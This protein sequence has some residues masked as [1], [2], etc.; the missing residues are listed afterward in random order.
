MNEERLESTAELARRLALHLAELGGGGA[1][2]PDAADLARLV[3]LAFFAGLHEEEAR[4]SGVTL[5]WGTAVDACTAAMALAT[6]VRATPK[7]IAK[8]APTAAREATS[9][10]LRRDGDE[11]VVWA[12][13]Q[14]GPE[15]ELPLT[16]RSPAAGVL[17]VDFRGAPAALYARGE[18]LFL[19]EPNERLSAAER[20]TS[21]FAEWRSSG[22]VDPRAAVVTRIAARAL[23]HGH[24][25]MIL[26]VPTGA[27]PRGVRMH[28]EAGDGA[29]LLAARYES[30][31]SHVDH[32]ELLARIASAG[33]GGFGARDAPQRRF[34]GAIDFVARLTAIDNALML[35]TDLHVRGFG[36]QVVEGGAPLAPFR[37]DNPYTGHSHVDDI[38]TFKGTRHPAGVIFCLRQ[39]GAAAAIIASQD[40]RLSLVTKQ[41]G[42][43]VEV[44]GS[45]ERGFGW[46]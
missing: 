10:A 45:Y 22:S 1:E 31:A 27:T 17:R 43:G 20:L 24:G 16:V 11:V 18:I 2:L 42:D 19:G 28:Y 3:E 15:A 9:L 40:S 7:S 4:R 39:E 5:T 35:D 23:A 25:G 8:L 34:D 29:H 41:E 13:L 21:A 6:P 46:K 36:V 12:L 44:L 33:S 38:T 26:I 37:H 14:H 30:L 32:G